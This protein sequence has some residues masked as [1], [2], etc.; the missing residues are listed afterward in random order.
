MLPV[1]VEV[2]HLTESEANDFLTSFERK[3]KNIMFSVLETD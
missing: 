2:S 3:K 1:F